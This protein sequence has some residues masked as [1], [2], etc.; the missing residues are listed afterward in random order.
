M[1]FFSGGQYI[2][3]DK[4]RT[5]KRKHNKGKTPQEI[6][7]KASDLTLGDNSNSVLFEYSEEYPIMLSNFG[8]GSKL[9]HYYRRK[10]MDDGTR[11]KFDI[12]ETSVLLPEDKSPFSLFGKIHPGETVPTLQN[13]LY[14]APVFQHDTKS[15]DFLVGRSVTGHGTHW[16][17]RNIDNIFT[18]GQEFP[19]VEV[20]GTHS[21]RVTEAAKRRL[22]MISYR[23]FNKKRRL[24]AKQPWLGNVDIKEHLPGSDIAQNRGKMREF[25]AYTKETQTWAP[26]GADGQA[27]FDAPL[28]DEE[29]MRTWVKPE[30][31]CLLDSMQVGNRH[32][33]D[34]GYNKEGEEIDGE[35]GDEKEGQSSEQQLAPWHTTKNFL[36]ACQGKAMLQLHGEGDPSGRGEAFSFMKISMKGGF[37]AVGESASEKIATQ[38]ELGGHSY[39]VAKQQQAYEE[40]IGKIWVS[41]RQSLQS[42]LEHSD[43]EMDEDVE[44]QPPASFNR[45]RTPQSTIGTPA[46]HDDDSTSQFS[47]FSRA[48]QQGKVL[49]I[50]RRFPN[51]FGEMESREEI[52]VDRNVIQAYGRRR[53][54]KEIESIGINDL[55]PT[56][57][58]TKDKQSIKMITAE[59]NRLSKNKERRHGREKQKK[60]LNGMEGASPAAD[61]PG[62]AVKAGG[63]QRRCA[64]CGQAGHIKTNK[65]L[66]PM[67]NGKMKQGEASFDDSA[68]G[69]APT[70]ASATGPAQTPVAETPAAETPS[71]SVSFD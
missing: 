61:S 52:I 14:R 10:D 24:N 32:L 1:H 67:L 62:G 12:G 30:D 50:V 63:T 59:L 19:S 25:M 26:K 16:W 43:I 21:R 28:P 3:F 7:E 69:A 40:A 2:R 20:P 6:F 13:G 55:K 8:M 41:Q 53:R 22:K 11:P 66:C 4:L 23:I 36:N 64:N 37:K 49:K 18:V 33:E 68:F 70:P 48:N 45:G 60:L 9:I 65:K 58:T 54:Q 17:M 47:S 44:D 51:K 38:K 57:D 35:D 34:S 56:G 29:T 27:D 31:V 42:T 5:I 39:N 46:K 15:T 71:F